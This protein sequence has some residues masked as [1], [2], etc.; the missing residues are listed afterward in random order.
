MNLLFLVQ[1]RTKTVQPTPEG[2]FEE[3]LSREERTETDTGQPIVET[4]TTHRT[5]TTNT[6]PDSSKYK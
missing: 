1:E 3:F 4:I 5:Y 2:L 6:T